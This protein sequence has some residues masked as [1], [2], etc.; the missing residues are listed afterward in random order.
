MNLGSPQAMATKISMKSKRPVMT[1]SWEGTVVSSETAS[2]A[3]HS[4]Y[5]TR[6]AN[7]YYCFKNK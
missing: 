2:G 3:V 4:P 5:C 7:F 1:P 6:R